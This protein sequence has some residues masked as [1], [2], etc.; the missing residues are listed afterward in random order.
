L[1]TR[2][3]LAV[4]MREPVRAFHFPCH[5]LPFRCHGSRTGGTLPDAGTCHRGCSIHQRAGVPVDGAG[6][7]CR[8]AE[9]TVPPA[10]GAD[11][12]APDL[13]H[14]GKSTYRRHSGVR[15]DEGN[16]RGAGPKT[17]LGREALHPNLPGK[18]SDAGN[19][20][21]SGST[22]AV[23]IQSSMQALAS[24][25]A[26]EDCRLQTIGLRSPRQSII[27]DKDSALDWC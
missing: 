7:N 14:A 16:G 13:I 27:K 19:P 18:S 6:F 5:F 21:P 1:A 23:D 11:G 15:R 9:A 2:R 20:D 8:Q 17:L 4:D 24:V 22:A 12:P 3:V 25:V 26:G 10:G